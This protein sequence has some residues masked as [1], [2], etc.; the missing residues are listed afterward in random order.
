MAPFGASRAGLMS[1]RVDAIPDSVVS[2]PEDDESAS[3]TGLR[4]VKIETNVEWSAIGAR[5]SGNAAGI[6]NAEIRRDSDDTLMGSTSFDSKGAGD[7]FT[8]ELDN[9]LVSDERYYFELDAD[10]D[11]YT[12]GFYRADGEFPFI[13]DDEDLSIVDGSFDGGEQSDLTNN[14]D[15]IGNVG[16]D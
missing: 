4:G 14:I 15:Q 16:F 6:T 11:S 5:I 7:T 13:S 10:G 9:N 8:I 2:R 12:Q 1:T 3:Q